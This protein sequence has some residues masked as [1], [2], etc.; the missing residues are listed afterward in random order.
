MDFY[1]LHKIE[2][3]IFYILIYQTINKNMGHLQL[4]K[5]F[6]DVF[7]IKIYDNIKNYIIEND[8]MDFY[9]ISNND[10]YLL[11]KFGFRFG[12]LPIVAFCYCIN[13]C[14]VHLNNLIG[15][16]YINIST[17]T[18]NDNDYSIPLV[19]DMNARDGITLTTFDKYTIC[20]NKCV[21]Y[22]VD[23]KKFSRYT[24]EKGKFMYMICD[25]YVEQ[26]NL[27]SVV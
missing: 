27:L 7:G 21:Q 24:L 19:H 8:I 16:F 23:M 11:L 6:I 26:Y 9:M 22:M 3:K 5:E 17:D 14:K 13:K 4:E 20:R 10:P 18:I 15:E 25:K 12:I 1:C 2:I